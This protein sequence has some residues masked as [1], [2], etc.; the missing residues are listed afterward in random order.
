M[1]NWPC[2]LPAQLIGT[3]HSGYG[4]AFMKAAKGPSCVTAWVECEGVLRLKDWLSLNIQDQPIWWHLEAA[5]GE[6]DKFS[7]RH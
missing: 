1:E 4:K 2:N 5:K 3:A 7:I 6:S